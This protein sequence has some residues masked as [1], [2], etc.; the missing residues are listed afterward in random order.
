MKN[1]NV[2][3]KLYTKTYILKE[4]N[5]VYKNVE[6]IFEKILIMYLKNI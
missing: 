3:E 4:V 5:H 2:Y 1:I 6:Q